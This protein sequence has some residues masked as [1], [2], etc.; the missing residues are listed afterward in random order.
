MT[1]Y[2]LWILNLFVS[3]A[4]SFSPLATY[5]LQA[6]SEVQFY[7]SQD[8]NSLGSAIKNSILNAQESILIFTFSLSDPGII[9]ALN[10]KANEGLPV[11][12]V[13]DKEHLGEIK[14]KGVPNIEVVTRTSGE[15]HLHHKILVVDGR[16]IWVG[17][18]NFTTSAYK[19][20]ENLMVYFP[21][22]EL[23]QYLHKEAD[24]FRGQA[25]RIEH[26]PLLIPLLNQEIYFCLL[27]HEGYPPKKIEKSLNA[28]SKKFLIEKINQASKS[29]KI[30]MM[31]W[32]N[33]DLANAVIQAQLRG[34]KVQVVSNDLEGNIPKLI[35]A[36]ID[37][38]VNS[39]LGFMHNKLMWIDDQILVNGSANW[40]QSAFSRNDESFIVLEPMSG[41]QTEILTDYWDY[42]FNP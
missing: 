37:V 29:I 10:Q 39:K 41:E 11:T 12:V 5:P 27:P 14:T 4:C 6:A 16:D 1:K 36:G 15:G 9:D 3:L 28:L 38:K 31:L 35:A 30:A 13:I 21:S 8:R 22:S 25:P 26:D 42:L 23:G 2:R 40:S 18:A 34:V 17:S 33:N 20:Q 24:A 32:T 7:H 19:N